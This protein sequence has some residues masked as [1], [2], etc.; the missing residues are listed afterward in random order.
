MA[1][2]WSSE[3][4]VADYG[5]LQ[6]KSM[7]VDCLG[8]VTVIAGRKALTFV[9]LRNPT[10]PLARHPRQSK[11]EKWDINCVQ[12]NPHPSHAHNFVTAC[13]ERLDLFA[14][15]DGVC[16]NQCMMKGHSRSISD[17]DWSPFDVNVIASCSVDTFI[18]LWD[19]RDP[20]K[21]QSSFQT[22]AGASQVMWNKI[23]TNQFATTHEG[24]VR[25]WD[26]R[27]GN[28]PLTYIAAHLSKI[29]G[30]DW[31]PHS[32]NCLA[33]ASQDGSVKFWD[34]T[35]FRQA[36]GSMSAGCP[37][38]R[39][40]YTPF[41]HGLVTVA[42][43]QIRRGDNSLYLWTVED[44]VQLVHQFMG[45]QDAIL[46]FQWRKQTEEERDFQL[47]TWARDQTLRV[48][49]VDLQHQKLCGHDVGDLPDSEELSTMSL[50]SSTNSFE[51]EEGEGGETTRQPSGSPDS[52]TAQQPRTLKQEFSLVNVEIPNIV[53]EELNPTTRTCIV[54]AMANNHNVRLK[55]VFPD[56]YPNNDMPSLDILFA[57]INN[58]VQQR[59]HL[60][61]TDICLKHV[62]RNTN[63]LEPVLR[64]LATYLE[65][66]TI[67]DRRTPESE[68]SM[69]LPFT[70]KPTKQL[71]GHNKFSA[72][73]G[74]YHYL[75]D[76]NI[77]F[78]RTSGARFCAAGF[79]VVFGRAREAKKARTGADH[80]PKA[81]S[82]LTQYGSRARIR[83]SHTAPTPYQ[84]YS[85]ARS[86]PTTSDP[87]TIKSY[88]YKDQKRK[89]NMRMKSKVI[90][91]KSEDLD[92]QKGPHLAPV[93]IYDSSYLLPINKNLG[94]HY[95]IDLNDIPAM[96]RH[97]AAQAA[98]VGRK[99]LVQL[100]NLVTLMSDKRLAPSSN[101]DDGSPWGRHPFGRQ[102]L[103]HMMDFYSSLHDVQTLA[104]LCC[105]FWNKQ[106]VQRP[107]H[108]SSSVEYI[109]P[110]VAEYSP[111]HT[112]SSSSS[113]L[114][115]WST[116]Q[117]AERPA[118]TGPLPTSSSTASLAEVASHPNLPAFQQ[119]ER[120]SPAVQKMRRSN[121]WSFDIDSIE[122]YKF[123]DS[124]D[125][126]QKEAEREQ[127]QHEINS[128]MMDPGA[129]QQYDDYLRAYA[130]ILYQWGR[131]NQATHVLKF[132]S[133]PKE[134]HKGI[135]FGLNCHRCRKEVR[136][137]QC[138]SCKV[139]AFNCVICHI[140]V[141]GASNFCLTCGHGGHTNHIIHW[142][143]THDECPSGCGCKCIRGK[144]Y[145]TMSSYNS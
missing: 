107:L 110:T 87:F 106:E 142:F 71:H 105:V 76:H 130:N 141:R 4:I 39:A 83:S 138:G 26:P 17:I 116:Y 70:H 123:D 3:Q 5:D 78:P 16:T 88:Y 96:C 51:G 32:E 79:L 41:G 77:P 52:I 74:P 1:T 57:T 94:T 133:S 45:H 15:K 68:T 72:H 81:L 63:C 131:G 49:K 136:G 43:P 62:T 120:G 102:L 95:R 93:K 128:R 135:E 101:P 91:D 36:K 20:R 58:K 98:G 12:W 35:N 119:S 48:W 31:S 103:K 10:E 11:W 56:N 23:Q 60:G 18:H 127:F 109:P 6:A 46:E 125:T 66:L 118:H 47:V 121:S 38:W 124:K 99:D 134:Q 112:V 122:D 61:L 9:D 69:H 108:Q 44:N 2:M 22:V 144:T 139:L 73:Y 55:L 140:G 145:I 86:P 104:M 132:V 59:L 129:Q 117:L 33:T 24:D 7:A 19:V 137:P 90:K 82:D 37:V 113:L 64:Q 114:K 50:V 30:L 97:N 28:S 115:G 27:K 84:Q 40:R 8:L 54:L 29:H 13:N 25:L 92:K 143:K 67:D 85:F 14:W 89:N 34:V 42:V 21:P 53:V 80:T 111:Y 65:K 100:W 75:L 126:K